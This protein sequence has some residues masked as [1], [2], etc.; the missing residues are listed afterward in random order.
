[1]HSGIVAAARVLQILA[2]LAAPNLALQA[3]DLSGTRPLPPQYRVHADGS[4]TLRICFNWSCATRQRMTFSAAD[5]AEVARQMALC[6]GTDLADR[7]QRV[8][9]GI[10][11]ME[12]LAQKQQPLLANDEPVND[13]DRSREGRMDCID[14]AS[15]T[16][17]FLSVLRDL[18][19]LPGWSVSPPQVRDRFSPA[20]HWTA[21][22]VD[23]GERRPWAI[24]SWFRGNGHLPFVMPLADWQ[25]GR[26]AWEPPFDEHN[27]Y[28]RYSNE[29]CG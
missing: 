29:L 10:W 20:V 13:R 14:N 26:I 4:V 15:N 8:R 3:S 23:A 1:M 5:M 11:Q 2:A 24:D 16:T 28:P 7:L 18:E 25:D 22:A 6:P 19:L 9:I 17:T 21:V 12:V 27:P